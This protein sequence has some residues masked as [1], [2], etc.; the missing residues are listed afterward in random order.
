MT[1]T[2]PVRTPG[3]GALLPDGTHI[4]EEQFQLAVERMLALVE[5]LEA[6]R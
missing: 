2:P 1:Q 6:V 4:T 5:L 3:H